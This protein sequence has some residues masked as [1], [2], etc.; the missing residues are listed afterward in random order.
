[1]FQLMFHAP[2]QDTHSASLQLQQ[3]YRERTPENAL[4]SA[5]TEWAAEVEVTFDSHQHSDSF[6]SADPRLLSAR[7]RKLPRDPWGA[8]M[9]LQNTGALV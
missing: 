7:P 4:P 9:N 8:L 5:S 1:M 3:P 6:S 2:K